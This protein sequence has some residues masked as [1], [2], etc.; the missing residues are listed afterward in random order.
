MSPPTTKRPRIYYGWVMVFVALVSGAFTTGVGVWGP[1]LFVQSME[2][3]L[4]WSRTSI[5]AAL[6]IRTLLSGVFAPFFGPM[7]DRKHGAR[8]LAVAGALLFGGSLIGLRWVTELWQLYLLFG[9][10]GSVAQA[11]SGYILATAI[12]PKWFIRRRGIAMGI[13]TMGT[14]LGSFFVLGIG[15]TV[16]S[17]GWRDA[18]M[19]I[20]IVTT[21]VLLPLGFLVRRRPE[22]L[23][24]LPDN[25]PP[26][27]DMPAR[28]PGAAPVVASAAATG[29][30]PVVALEHSLTRRQAV[31]T[32]AFWLLIGVLAAAGFGLQGYQSN[33]V[34]YLQGEGF[35]LRQASLAVLMYGTASVIARLL[36]GYLADR[37]P[38][39]HLITIAALLIAAGI[40]IFINVA[41]MPVLVFYMMLAGLTIGGWVLLNP[42]I[43]ANYFGRAHLGSVSGLMRPVSTIAVAS[44]PVVVAALYDATGTYTWAWVMMAGTWALAALLVFLARPPKAPSR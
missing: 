2:A 1:S 24:L 21:V 14:G 29:A 33:W 23:G 3:E 30:A 28:A 19:A 8:A 38:V 17:L 7:L 41:S 13:A 15:S 25:D 11:G 20:G 10:V 5:Y 26:V 31:R 16:T 35:S 37:F 42:L 18:W 34:P 6:T 39:R 4:G 22:D 32:P 40:F 43:V 9:V 44:G 36:W 12:L 27:Q